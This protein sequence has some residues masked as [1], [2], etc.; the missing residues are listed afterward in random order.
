MCSMGWNF[1]PDRI[2]ALVDTARKY[3]AHIRINYVDRWNPTT[4]HANRSDMRFTSR[5]VSTARR[6][7]AGLRIF[8]S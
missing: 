3:Q 7:A 6:F 1:T 5:S 2:D 4:L 8:Q